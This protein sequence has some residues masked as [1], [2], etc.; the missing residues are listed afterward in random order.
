MNILVLNADALRLAY[1]GCYGS[2]WVPTPSL[3]RLTAESVV[4]DQH[5]V[6][7]LGFPYRSAWTGRYGPPL[8]PDARAENVLGDLLQSRGIVYRFQPITDW[9][10]LADGLPREL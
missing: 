9:N 5:V 6:D 8:A 4:F 7:S 10:A 2:D 1:L 3:D